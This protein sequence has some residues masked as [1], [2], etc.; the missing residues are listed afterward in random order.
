MKI[1]GK[2]IQ[3]IGNKCDNQ[4]KKIDESSQENWYKK[5]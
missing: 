3:E 4:L 1:N 5:L 2:K